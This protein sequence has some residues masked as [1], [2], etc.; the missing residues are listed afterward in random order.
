MSEI[1]QS[2]VALLDVRAAAA[3]V[4]LSVSTLNKLRI[5]GD[6]PQFVKLGH[7][8]RYRPEDLAAWI[9]ANLHRSTSE[10]ATATWHRG[11]AER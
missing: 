1:V 4:G 5:A 9:A 2:A 8:V 11:K 10:E 6:G 7:A 3:R